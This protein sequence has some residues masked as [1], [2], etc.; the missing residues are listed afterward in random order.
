[1]KQTEETKQ[2]KFMTYINLSSIA[3][4]IGDDYKCE[5]YI[6]H[7]EAMID[8]L[9]EN[10]SAD[11]LDGNPLLVS[12]IINIHASVYICTVQLNSNL[13]LAR[14]CLAETRLIFKYTRE[15]AV[16][17]RTSLW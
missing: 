15:L 13:T 3:R 5:E 4:K 17:A 6:K 9:F 14:V 7:A 12:I 8:D 11:D 1:M 10:P 2:L 16:S